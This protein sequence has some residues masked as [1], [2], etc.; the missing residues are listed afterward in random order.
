MIARTC[1]FFSDDRVVGEGSA[2]SLLVFLELSVGII[3]GCVIAGTANAVTYSHMA[4]CRE[5]G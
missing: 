1:F 3:E 5:F 2:V 4:F